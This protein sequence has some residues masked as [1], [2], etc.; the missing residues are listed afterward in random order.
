VVTCSILLALGGMGKAVAQTQEGGGPGILGELRSRLTNRPAVEVWEEARRN[1]SAVEALPY[2]E[3]LVGR[4]DA[5]AYAVRASLW[6]LSQSLAKASQIL[7]CPNSMFK[8]EAAPVIAFA[9]AHG[10]KRVLIEKNDVFCT[11]VPDLKLEALVPFLEK[12]GL[13]VVFVDFNS[14]LETAVRETAKVL[15]H[16]DKVEEVLA[17]YNKALEKTRKK[18]AGKS[19]A[20]RVVILKGTYQS[21]TGK[22]FVQVEAPGGYAD[23]FLLSATGSENV[24]DLLAGKNAEPAKGHYTIR[25]LDGLVEAAPDAIVVTGDALAVQKV[26]SGAVEKNPALADVPAVKAHAVYSLPAYVDS[27]VIEYPTLLRRWADVLSK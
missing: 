12:E 17:D 3:S 9:K 4:N 16:T 13:E 15:G 21:E 5:P 10:I 23:T 19:F 2:M 8:K 24:G 11:Y 26:L 14:G 7:G 1:P 22:A 20:K 25:K 27:G 18:M 6:P